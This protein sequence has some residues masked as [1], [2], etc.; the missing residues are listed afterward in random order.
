MTR[1]QIGTNGNDTSLFDM[2]ELNEQLRVC[3]SALNMPA[4]VTINLDPYAH[5]IRRRHMAVAKHSTT[6]N[7]HFK[8]NK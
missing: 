8:S 3:N 2:E 5:S 6:I 7:C 1:G 4:D